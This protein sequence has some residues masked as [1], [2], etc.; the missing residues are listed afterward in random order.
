LP[1]KEVK[2]MTVRR[3]KLDKIDRKI[4]KELQENGRITNV[5]LSRRAGIS[6]PPCLRRVRALEDAKLIES[7]HAHLNAQALGYGITVVANI[8]LKSQNDTDIKAFTKKC[9]EWPMVRVAYMMSGD[10]DFVLKIVAH[11]W[12]DYQSFLS[13][14]LTAFPSVETVKATP[15]LRTIKFEPGVPIDVN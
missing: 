15:L 8:K 14:E 12:E 7:Y 6:A 2:A 11:D 9:L 3:M 4:L 1:Q 10:V 5:E 13:Q